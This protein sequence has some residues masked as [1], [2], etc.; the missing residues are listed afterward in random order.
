MRIFFIAL[1]IGVAWGCG[2]VPQEEV[3]HTGEEKR[4]FFWSVDWHPHKDQ[5]VVGGSNDTFL[6]LFSSRDFQPI[7][8]YPYQG[9]I[10]KSKWHPT[11][12][13]L[14]ISV[15]DGKSTS[16]ILNLDDD[17]LTPLDSVSPEGA[18]AIGWNTSGDL[19]AVGDYQGFLTLF[20]DE[21]NYLQRVNTHQKSLIGLDWHPE[22]NLIVAVGEDISLYDVESDSLWHIEDRTEEIE[23]LML[24]VAWHPSGTFF[25]TGDYGD[26]EYGYPP[27]LQYWTAEG[28]RIRAI[29]G[30]KAELRNL[31]WSRDGELLATASEKIRLW[32]KGGKLLAEDSAQDL[33]WGIGWNG[34]ATRLVATDVNKKI[35][36]WDRD[37]NR[38]KE[39]NH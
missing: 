21:G 22:K 6:R 32:D 23:T 36:F 5:I 1:C 28:R 33:L 29:E 16:A 34:D 37:L 26:F 9:T 11:Q 14:A 7:K 31:Q 8:D 10:T 3:E 18:R 24:C 4:W 35:I 20:D 17:Q 25:V 19:L 27:L 12:H 13:K 39:L 15:Q 30:S 38:I 2:L